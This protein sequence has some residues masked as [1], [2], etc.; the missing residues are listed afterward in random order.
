MPEVFDCAEPAQLMSGMRL[1]RKAI[2]SGELVVLP[3]DTVYGVAA[4]AFNPE[5]V[6]RLL[7]AKGRTRQSPPPVLVAGYEAIQALAA[8][9]LPEVEELAKRF[10]PGALTIVVPARRSLAWDLG[11]THGTVA[12]RTPDHQVAREL[13]AETG[14]LA[15]SSANL[16]GQPA[17]TTASKA[18]EMLG[19]SVA[20]YLDSGA[21]SGGAPST[22]IDASRLHTAD[23]HL[24]LLRLGAVTVDEIREV[25]GDLLVVEEP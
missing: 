3:T 1:A 15:V 7:H 22:I 4:D 9:I 20:V 24:H 21:S 16:T 8:M 23:K 17:A 2:A 14:P 10:W 11:E 19:D 25:V 13:L 6:Q 18:K 12:L 5:A